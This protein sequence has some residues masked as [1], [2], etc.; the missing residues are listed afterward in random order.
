LDEASP[1]FG[2]PQPETHAPA[3]GEHTERWRTDLG[4]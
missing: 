1:R 4:L 3:L 2:R